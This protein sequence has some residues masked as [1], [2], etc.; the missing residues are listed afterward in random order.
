MRKYIKIES[1]DNTDIIIFVDRIQYIQEK[2]NGCVIGP[3][4]GVCINS[5]AEFEDVEKKLKNFK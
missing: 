2:K 4:H 1:T 5:G 3:E